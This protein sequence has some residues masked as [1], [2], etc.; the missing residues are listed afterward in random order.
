LR[1]LEV[2]VDHRLRR[3]GQSKVSGTAMGTLR[4]AIRILLT[5][6]RLAI[7]LRKTATR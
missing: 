7:E 2:P 4:A 6:T 5:F 3:G 1:I